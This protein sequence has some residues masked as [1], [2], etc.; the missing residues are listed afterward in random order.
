M[1]SFTFDFFS[2]PFTIPVKSRRKTVEVVANAV[3]TLKP[4]PKED[5]VGEK[6]KSEEQETTRCPKKLATIKFN[7]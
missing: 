2:L 3:A 6:R 1:R 7:L 4:K 5:A